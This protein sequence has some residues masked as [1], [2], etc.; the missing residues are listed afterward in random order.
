VANA[1]TTDAPSQRLRDFIT[2]L[3]DEGHEL[4]DK[5]NAFLASVRKA[6][7]FLA[8][9]TQGLDDDDER[10]QTAATESGIGTLHA[11][12]EHLLDALVDGLWWRLPCD[13]GATDEERAA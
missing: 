2:N 4:E 13:D 8:E 12:E 1:T 9:E 10:F 3:I 5:V 11:I 6:G 7:E